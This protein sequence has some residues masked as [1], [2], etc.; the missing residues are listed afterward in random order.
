MALVVLGEREM[1]VDLFPKI[2]VVLPGVVGVG[3]FWFLLSDEAFEPVVVAEEPSVLGVLPGVLGADVSWYSTVGEA[4][5]PRV[6][7]ELSAI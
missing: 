5:D 4:F 1:V 2:E 6:A 3:R 7:G